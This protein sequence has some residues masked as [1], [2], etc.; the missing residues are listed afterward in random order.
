MARRKRAEAPDDDEPAMDISSLIDVCFLLLIYFIVTNTIQPKEMDL[1]L[2][3][4]SSV[5]S[6]EQPPE[7]KPMLI[8]IASSGSITV[9]QNEPLD[10]AATVTH[11]SRKL[12]QLEQ[13]LS[14]YKG[15]FSG[16]DSEPLVQVAVDGEAP[17]QAVMDVI[18]TL[19]GLDINKV[20]FTDFA[21]K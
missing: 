3:L 17:Q 19:V 8:H 20:T 9:N 13:R 18:N 21:N 4:P 12:P 11:D 14:I 5:P 7:I 15:A 10:T 16:S 1:P 2:T 6:T